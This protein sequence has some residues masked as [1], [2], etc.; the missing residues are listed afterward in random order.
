MGIWVGILDILPTQCSSVTIIKAKHSAMVWMAGID[1]VSELY[2]RAQTQYI[3]TQ[4]SRIKASAIL[5]SWLR[6]RPLRHQA[7][8][9]RR[10]F[11]RAALNNLVL[12]CYDSYMRKAL[13]KVVKGKAKPDEVRLLARKRLA[14]VVVA[15][16]SYSKRARQ[17]LF[18]KA[19][20]SLPVAKA[21]SQ[22]KLISEVNPADFRI[23]RMPG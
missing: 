16:S 10:L 3:E 20:C 12:T 7:L 17:M 18:N 5:S 9:V 21:V 2:C 1:H 8:A 14:K 6:Q 22:A 15:R 23:I 13:A 4:K 19:V 11:R